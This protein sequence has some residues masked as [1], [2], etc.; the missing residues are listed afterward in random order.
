M[1]NNNE[2]IKTKFSSSDDSFNHLMKYLGYQEHL[3]KGCNEFYDY[4]YNS[5]INDKSYMMIGIKKFEENQKDEIK[6]LHKKYWNKNDI[7][8]S[9]LIFPN[10]IL[11]YNNYNYNC[12]KSILYDSEKKESENLIELQLLKNENIISGLFWEEVQ[13]YVKNTERVD[14]RLLMNLQATVAKISEDK[15]ISKKSAF[16]FVSKCI[17]VKYLEDRD[18]LRYN[19]FMKFNA[20]TFTNLLENKNKQEIYNFF[21]YLHLRFNGDLFD[22]IELDVINSDSAI[23]CVHEFFNGT[24]IESGQLNLFP[25]DFSII[26]I[27]LISSIYENFFDV[28]VGDNLMSSTKKETGSFY[29][30]YYLADFMLSRNVNPNLSYNY[31]Y[32]VLDPSCGSGVFLV[33][34]FK[35]I[36]NGYINQG[37][38]VDS[39]LL[40][41]I[42]T[43][44]VYGIDSNRKALEITTFS[45][46]IAL[47]DFL[48]P[49]DLEINDFKF[50]KLINLTLYES[51]FFNEDNKFN[52]LKFDLIIGNP[53]WKGIKG[54]HLQYCKRNDIFISDKQIA[55]AFIM[56]A[57]DF[58]HDNTIIS[59]IIPNSIFYNTNASMFRKQL[60]DN[61]ELNEIINLNNISDKLFS[62]A[63][64]PC[65]IIRYKKLIKENDN[66][67]LVTIFKPNI[68]SKLFN[69]IV[70][71]L[72]NST[73]I[74]SSLFY[75]DDFLWNIVLYGSHMDYH[76]IKKLIKLHTL[77]EFC[78]D[79]GLSVSQGFA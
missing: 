40:R 20:H 31:N 49:K 34:A 36:V 12:D 38:L 24:E 73:Y 77:E 47:L 78:N 14:K 65:S 6:I 5:T 64:H 71:D 67:I 29:T 3:R 50:P 37:K 22:N 51:S 45:L 33:G 17:F 11:V 57:K 68:F 62:G 61:F 46:Y 18:M 66:N 39:I 2:F 10:E 7:P 79:H 69:K 74:R 75:E 52:N 16:G 9:I 4:T 26:P 44:Q 56:R 15:T 8:V 1:S 21:D 54:D 58:V 59:L 25:Y 63:S 43:N 60:L 28:S 42:L 23:A 35:R 70:F 27:E 13:K 19:T 30:P 72:S 32:K 48:E 55:Q 53:P 76:L 41:H